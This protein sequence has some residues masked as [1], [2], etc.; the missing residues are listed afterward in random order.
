[1][2]RVVLEFTKHGVNAESLGG[3]VPFVSI[4]AKTGM[5]LDELEAQLLMSSQALEL[6]ADHDDQAEVCLVGVCASHALARCRPLLS[7]TR[8]KSG[9]A[10]C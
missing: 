5:G 2:E 4:S 1:M 10:R 3:D 7:K 6:R 9:W 8:R